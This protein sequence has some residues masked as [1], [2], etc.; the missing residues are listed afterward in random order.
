MVRVNLILPV[1]V[2]R[3]LHWLELLLTPHLERA[4]K[5]PTRA[6]ASRSNTL[7]PMPKSAAI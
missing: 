4:F 2:G 1:I 3:M 5:F 7:A 6:V